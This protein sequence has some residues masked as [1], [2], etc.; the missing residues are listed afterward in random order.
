MSARERTDEELMQAYVAGD[1]HAFEELF[2]RYAP[3]ISRL[4]RRSVAVADADDLVQQT[5]LQLH[6]A[7]RDFRADARVRPWLYTIAYNLQRQY[8]RRRGRKPETAVEGPLM[9]AGQR[10]AEAAIYDGQLRSALDTLPASQ[11]EAIVLHWFEGLSYA[12]VAQVVG[13]KVSAVRVR[14][15]R[16]YG[17][18]RELLGDG[19][20]DPTAPAYASPESE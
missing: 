10:P 16:G 3:R 9:D 1:R 14:A 6:R 15:H 4:M 2:A 18:L 5:F 13:A 17:R 19:V 7:R 12:E 11:R 8:F 20:T